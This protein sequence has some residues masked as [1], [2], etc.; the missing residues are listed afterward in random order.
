[1]RFAPPKQLRIADRA[2]GLN[3]ERVR[4]YNERLVLSLLLQNE[5]ISRLAIGERT[6]LSAQTISVIVRSLEH[7]GL[8]SM[9]EAMRGR[10]GPPTIPVLL[11]ADGAYAVGVDL[12]PWENE[13]VLID[14]LGAIRFHAKL[15]SHADTG[16]AS[17]ADIRVAVGAALDAAPMGARARVA[18]IGLAMPEDGR[19]KAEPMIASEEELNLHR[20]LERSFD[21]PVFVQNDV[22]A[23]AGGE[24]MFGVTKSTSNHLFCFL[25]AMLHSRLVLN[26][27]VYTG[28]YN[29]SPASLDVGVLA[30]QR[31]LTRDSSALPD[32]HDDAA[33]QGLG[34]HLDKWRSECVGALKGS[35][36]ALAQFVDIRTVVI[37]GALPTA[38]SDAICADL[39]RSLPG[40]QVIASA[41]RKAPKAVGAGG[42]PLI[43][44]FAVHV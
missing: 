26:N 1:M 36:R 8:L 17:A 31:R 3:P 2:D 32:L 23:A 18:G 9:G 37:S 16:A 35:I 4:S 11:N 5:G 28:N 19:S 38:V 15:P 10:V 40:L 27:H 14:F 20:E 39:Q 25:G 34:D 30:L 21:L 12:A 43:S 7:E 42:L 41:V 44:R 22:T 6:K 24:M 33:W 13:V 29:V